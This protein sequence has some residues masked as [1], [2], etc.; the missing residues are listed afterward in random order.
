VCITTNQ[1]DT[2]SDLNPNL[3][4]TTKQHAVVCSQ[5]NIVICAMYAKKFVQD[6]KLIRDNIVAPSLQ[7]FVVIVTLSINYVIIVTLLFFVDFASHPADI[8]DWCN[9]VLS[10]VHSNRL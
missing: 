10:L 8:G 2:K 4:P 1:P 6:E 9:C 7:L 5:L 3:N